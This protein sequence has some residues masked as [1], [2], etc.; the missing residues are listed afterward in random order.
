MPEDVW[1][2]PERAGRARMP[3]ESRK[4]PNALREQEEPECLERAGRAR[5]P[6]EMPEE[7][8]CL[9]RARRA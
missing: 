2:C 9:E 1:R 4:S 7:P 6:G 5:M 8:E 3:G